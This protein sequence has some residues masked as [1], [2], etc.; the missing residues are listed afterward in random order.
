MDPNVTPKPIPATPLTAAPS[1]CHPLT[2]Q[3]PSR[4]PPHVVH[5]AYVVHQFVEVVEAL[6]AKYTARK[7]PALII[8]VV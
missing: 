2:I 5:R 7:Q 3:L 4:G 6:A 1:V 8:I